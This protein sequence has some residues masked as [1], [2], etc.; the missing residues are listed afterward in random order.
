MSTERVADTAV[1]PQMLC[2]PLDLHCYVFQ[3]AQKERRRGVGKPMMPMTR[4][5]FPKVK[6]V[7]CEGPQEL[8]IILRGHAIL[9]SEQKDPWSL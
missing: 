1:P 2:V 4:L 6:P 5:M 8:N 7:R 9:T 3:M